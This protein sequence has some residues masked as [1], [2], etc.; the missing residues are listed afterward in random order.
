MTFLITAN[1]FDK[2]TILLIW[3]LFAHPKSGLIT[4]VP[5][6]S[7]QREFL[8]IPVHGHL[9][10]SFKV[11]QGCP[12][13]PG[14]GVVFTPWGY[15]ESQCPHTV[16]KP[17]TEIVPAGPAGI[18]RVTLVGGCTL[19]AGGYDQGAVRPV[20]NFN[21]F[22]WPRVKSAKKQRWNV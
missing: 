13:T 9:P 21:P 2:L 8:I 4:K 6:L 17:I 20:P 1:S 19:Q 3:P 11:D 10:L 5:M 15:A 18:R 14:E 12:S 7:I 16:P 22:R